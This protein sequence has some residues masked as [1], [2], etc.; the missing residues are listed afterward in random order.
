MPAKI[1]VNYKGL[2]LKDEDKLKKAMKKF[3]KLCETEGII[4]DVKRK[5]YYEKPSDVRRRKRKTTNK[6]KGLL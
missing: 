1:Y 5:A 3:K 2:G 4:R 6:Q